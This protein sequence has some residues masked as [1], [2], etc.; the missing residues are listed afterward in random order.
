MADTKKEHA[1]DRIYDTK[2]DSID[3]IDT[4]DFI[5]ELYKD[6]TEHLYGKEE[7]KNLDFFRKFAFNMLLKT[8]LNGK[9]QYNDDIKENGIDFANNNLNCRIQFLIQNSVEYNR[10]VKYLD[11]REENKELLNIKNSEEESEEM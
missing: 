10:L 3:I 1:L 5:K 8:Y 7:K 4:L 2:E 9:V 11:W 6:K